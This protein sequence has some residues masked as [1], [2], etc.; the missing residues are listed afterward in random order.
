VTAS[1]FFALLKALPLVLQII[2]ALADRAQSARDRGEGYDDAVAAALKQQHEELVK[3]TEA[4]RA[5]ADRHAAD[6]TDEAFDGQF[7]RD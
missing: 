7:K 5:A 2:S 3:G 6:P 1:I 4:M